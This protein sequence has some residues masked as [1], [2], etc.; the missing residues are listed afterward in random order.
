MCGGNVT[1]SGKKALRFEA[2]SVPVTTPST[3]P[4]TTTQTTTRP[5]NRSRRSQPA[6]QDRQWTSPVGPAPPKDKR[7]NITKLHKADGFIEFPVTQA[8]VPSCRLLAYYVR[9]DGETVADNIMVDIEDK[10]EN[11]V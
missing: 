6:D 8:M 11:Q 4:S 3:Q 5:S 10:L 9:Q 7:P 2:K 1:A